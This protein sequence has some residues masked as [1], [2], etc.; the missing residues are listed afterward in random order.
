MLLHI[1]NFFFLIRHNLF[2]HWHWWHHLYWYL[3]QTRLMLKSALWLKYSVVVGGAR[4]DADVMLNEA[5]NKA[6]KPSI[7]SV[8]VI[9]LSKEHRQDVITGQTLLFVIWPAVGLKQ[10]VTAR[11]RPFQKYNHSSVSIKYYTLVLWSWL[12]LQSELWL[13]NC[14]TLSVWR[15]TLGQC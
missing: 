15:L 3:N 10:K 1:L 9:W 8:A 7:M 14:W 12:N 5:C 2:W 13:T 4:P 11:C 6:Q